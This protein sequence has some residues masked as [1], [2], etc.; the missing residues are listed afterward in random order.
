M[1]ILRVGRREERENIGGG[2]RVI[3]KK[4]NQKAMGEEERGLRLLVTIKIMNS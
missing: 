4:E 3:I 1:K 2:R